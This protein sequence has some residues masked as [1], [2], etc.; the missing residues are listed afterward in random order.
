LTKIGHTSITV[1]PCRAH[2]MFIASVS[3]RTANFDAE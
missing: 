1:M 3:P 2:S